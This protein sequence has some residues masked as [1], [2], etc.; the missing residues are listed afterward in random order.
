MTGVTPCQLT[1]CRVGVMVYP[2][3]FAGGTASPVRDN[4]GQA[5]RCDHDLMYDN[6]YSSTYSETYH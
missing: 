1:D 3:G 5:Q 6:I 2:E 4:E